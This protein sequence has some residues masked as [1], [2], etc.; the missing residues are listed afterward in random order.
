VK[1]GSDDRLTSAGS[2]EKPCSLCGGPVVVY[3]I[4][5]ESTGGL[6]RYVVDGVRIERR[7]EGE[8]EHGKF[9]E[10]ADQFVCVKCLGVQVTVSENIWKWTKAKAKVSFEDI[11]RVFEGG[12]ET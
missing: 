10:V 9:T 7:R 6:F 5:V 1:I 3:F 11:K 12:D 8:D 2:E 4:R